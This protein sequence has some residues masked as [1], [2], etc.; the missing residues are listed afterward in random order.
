MEKPDLDTPLWQVTW[1]QFIEYVEGKKSEPQEDKNIPSQ[2]EKYI[3][4]LKSLAK[5]L[6]ISHHHAWRLKNEGVFD[7]AIKQRGRTILIN[8]SK[9]IE[10]FTDKEYEHNKK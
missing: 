8:K 9:V 5:L 7:D 1:G 6:G 4:G 10:L 2:D 3:R